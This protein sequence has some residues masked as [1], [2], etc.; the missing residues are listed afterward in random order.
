MNSRL[1][2]V[3]APAGDH[4]SLEAALAAGADSVYLGLDDGFN[5]RARAKNFDIEGL[6]DLVRKVH[7]AGARLYLTLNTLVFEPELPLLEELLRKIAVSGVD[8][9]I[10]QDPAVCLIARR[11]S[12]R[13]EL[14]ASTQM[15]I[16]SPEGARFAMGLG[17]TRVVL[18]RELSVDEIRTYRELAP[19]LG[20]EHLELEVF[21]HGAL[22]MSWSG[23]CLTSE[24]WGGRSANRGQCAQ[25]CRLPYGLEV[26]GQAR[27]LEKDGDAL[28]YFLSPKDL[29]G[30]RSVP[31]LVELGVHTLKIEG[32]LK[33]PSYVRTA[34]ESFSRWLEAIH[35]G[36][37]E[38]EDA[39]EQLAH[40]LSAAHRVYSRGFTDGFLAGPDHQSLVDGRHPKNRGR[41]LGK[42]RRVDVNR[43]EVV[44]WPAPDF[45]VFIGALPDHTP[46][47]AP[48]VPQRGMGVVFDAFDPEDPREAGGPLFDVSPD[49]GGANGWVLRFGDPGPDLSRVKAGQRVWVNSDPAI[50]SET[51]RL[52]ARPVTGRV[53]VTLVVSGRGGE[54]IAA[55]LSAGGF[56]VTELGPALE[57]AKGQGLDEGQLADKLGSFGGT[58]FHLARLDNRLPVGLFVSP[59]ELK[60][61]RRRLVERLEALL[62]AAPPVVLPEGSVVAELKVAQR[63]ATEGRAYLPGYLDDRPRLAE[64]LENRDIGAVAAEGPVCPVEHL[65]NRD[66][67]ARLVPLCRLPHQL[68]V[69]IA[70]GFREVELDWMEM[71]GLGRAVERARGAGLKVTI[72]TTRV[73]KPGE[74]GFDQRIA[75]LNPDAVLARHWGALVHFNDR[76]S[77][78]ESG[79]LVHG[80]FSL[81][82]TNSIT[83]HHLFGLGCDSLTASHDLDEAQLFALLD[84]VP[85]D[86]MAVVVHHHI[87]T[88]HTEHCVYAATLSSGKDYRT[89]GRPCDTRQVSLV[90]PKGLAHPVITDVG[91]RNTVFEARAQSAASLVPR[92][93]ERG[94][95]R[96]RVELV[97]ESEAETRVV[98]ESYRELVLGRLSPREVVRRVG[99]H[100]QFGVVRGVARAAS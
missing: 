95:R 72:A 42:V 89:C 88:F 55:T 22:C 64:H 97:R 84:E 86:R 75:K 29:A 76:R 45:P 57:V 61:L 39:Q 12:E 48:L 38:T 67:G 68:E 33:G 13:L 94:V 91:C 14:H 87:P 62:D 66:V 27:N 43:R 54:P 9:L 47:E 81:N 1:P 100:E 93:I 98:L 44:V 74:E 99:G 90:D 58:R 85:A 36:R 5:A 30:H 26:D 16:S 37:H 83:A 80:D 3:L 24:A 15:T 28:R 18:P 82:V 69:A 6:P 7:R 41:F 23:Q 65:E 31:A 92:L 77:R 50:E 71:V 21:V 46:P 8:A 10:V 96:L 79:P 63:A 51:R 53:A 59:S 78:H 40:D 52:L 70:L 56:E 2:E 4:A 34:V 17:V 19:K 49:A 11:L 25:S 35:Q 20:V 60:A 32:R 73:Q